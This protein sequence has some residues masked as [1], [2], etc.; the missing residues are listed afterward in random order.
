MASKSVLKRLDA[1]RRLHR[2]RDPPRQHATAEPIEHN[3]QIDE[4]ARHRDVGDVHRPHLVWPRDLGAAQQIR[5][6][7]VPR[8]GLRR[9]RTAIERLYP[10]PLHQRLHVTTANLAPLDSQQASQH[11]APGEWELQMQSVETPHDREVGFR[12]RTRQVV[13]AATADVQSFRLLGDRQIVRTVDHRLALSSPAL[14]SAPSKKSFSSVSSP[15]FA[16]N[17]FTST[18]GCVAPPPPG[19][20]TLAAPPSSCAFHDVI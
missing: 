20:K 5:I 15:I 6:N 4:A 14:L 3:G 19:P 12:H 13:D 9:T 10:H 1:E 11:P 7:L 8:L 16:C 2:D 18:A 17:D